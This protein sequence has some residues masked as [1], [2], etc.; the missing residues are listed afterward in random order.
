MSQH[1][2]AL[3]TL[4]TVLLLFGTAFAVGRARGR[5]QI[6]APATSGHPAFERAFRAQMNTLE[7]AVMF[8]P[9]LW[10]AAYYGFS[11][12]AGIAGL[13]WIV[14]RVWYAVAYL[15]EAEKREGG[16][17]LGMLGWAG[18]LVLAAIGVGRALLAG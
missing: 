10:L 12:W 17:V 1:L 6:K 5:Y 14:G 8:L 7:A 18:T 15:K 2:P 9:L 16:F 13:V 3:V 11:L 4:L